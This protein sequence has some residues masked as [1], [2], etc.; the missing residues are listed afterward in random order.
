MAGHGEE[1][2][3]DPGAAVGGAG[4][5]VGAP[6]G[7]LVGRGLLQQR[8]LA[9]HD[10]QRVVQLMADPGQ[11]G[12]QRVQLLGL[13]ERLALALH[14]GHVG[15]GQDEAALRGR[16]A[17]DQQAPAVGHVDLDFAPLRRPAAAD[18]DQRVQPLG[19]AGERPEPRRQVVD[20]GAGETLRRLA[21]EPGIG[22]VADHQA[23]LPVV[24]REPVAQALHRVVEQLQQALVLAL[25]LLAL[26]HVEVDRDDVLDRAVV[27]QQRDLG[28]PDGP[29][30]VV[31]AAPLHLVEWQVARRVDSTILSSASIA[32][33][34]SGGVTWRLVRPITSAMSACP[35]S[36]KVRLTMR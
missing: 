7:R 6:A 1:G 17:G 31:D 22:A 11:Q 26:G 4:D 33:A 9:D 36:R 20:R 27:P 8:G 32:A 14:L 19:V 30:P 28:G 12:P 25:H 29:R 10:R 35:T 13:V 16:V 2:A 15:A 21:V 5:P 34:R 23:A 24:D 18:A 3:H